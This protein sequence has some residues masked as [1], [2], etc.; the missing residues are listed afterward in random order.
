MRLAIYGLIITIRLTLRKLGYRNLKYWQCADVYLYTFHNLK[1]ID[2]NNLILWPKV[3]EH[4]NKYSWRNVVFH[5]VVVARIFII[6]LHVLQHLY[7]FR[8]YFNAAAHSSLLTSRLHIC[9]R[10]NFRQENTF[11][12]QRMLKKDVRNGSRRKY[13]GSIPA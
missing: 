7:V 12:I 10:S 11:S 2:L 1:W 9:I 8:W 5:T 3:S 6:L 4:K 13:P